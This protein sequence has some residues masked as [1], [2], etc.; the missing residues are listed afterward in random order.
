MWS[1]LITTPNVLDVVTLPLKWVAPW[2]RL[3]A[4]FD[5][6]KLDAAAEEAWFYSDT[7]TSALFPRT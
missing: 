3:L 7:T 1:F 2:G 6:S 4:G 5:R